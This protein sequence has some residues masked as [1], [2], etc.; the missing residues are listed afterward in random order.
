MYGMIFL[1][2]QTLLLKLKTYR[3]SGAV[4]QWVRPPLNLIITLKIIIFEVEIDTLV[5]DTC[6]FPPPHTH[7]QS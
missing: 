6:P 7:T 1:A 2:F 5:V 3:V 4:N